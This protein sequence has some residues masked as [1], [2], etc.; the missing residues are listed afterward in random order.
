MGRVEDLLERYKRWLLLGYSPRTAT[1]Y[2]SVIKK[3]LDFYGDDPLSLDPMDEAEAAIEFIEYYSDKPR[4]R[5]VAAYAIKNFYEFLGRPDIA[6]RIPSPRGAGWTP[7]TIPLD[8]N[9]LKNLI[10]HQ[11]DARARAM[12]CTAYDLALRRMEVTL[13]NR[14]EFNPETC[15][16]IVYRVKGPKGQPRPNLMKLSDWCCRLVREYLATRT[17]K[18]RALFVNRHGDRVSRELVRRVFKEFARRLGMP[19]VRFHQIRHTAITEHAEN[20]RDVVALAKYAGHRNPQSTLI[21][22]HLSATKVRERL[23]KDNNK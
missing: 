18:S 21:Y 11:P 4:S 9:L 2:I 3:Y 19:E 16:I 8:Y 22:I 1:T 14:D 6:S 5:Q 15:E 13:L 20:E 7:S 12:L 23:K 17:D 10:A